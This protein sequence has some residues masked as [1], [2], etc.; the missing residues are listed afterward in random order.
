M[1][2]QRRPYWIALGAVLHVTFG[3]LGFFG[4][5]VYRKAPPIPDAVITENGQTLVVYEDWSRR[6]AFGHT[7]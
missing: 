3:V 4:T 6:S 5:E 7:C 2:F 1:G